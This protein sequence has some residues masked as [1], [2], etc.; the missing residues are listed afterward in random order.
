MDN[1]NDIEEIY[2]ST[3][4]G[5]VEAPQDQQKNTT[6][7]IAQEFDLYNY[8]RSWPGPPLNPSARGWDM[9]KRRPA[10]VGRKCTLWHHTIHSIPLLTGNRQ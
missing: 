2:S 7:N 3:E 9:A 4:R 1:E 8:I 5:D 10:A 6:L